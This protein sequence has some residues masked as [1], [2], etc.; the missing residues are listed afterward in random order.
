MTEL[1]PTRS[2]RSIEDVRVGL[3]LNGVETDVIGFSCRLLLVRVVRC[4]AEAKQ[5]MLKCPK[6]RIKRQGSRRR[7]IAPAMPL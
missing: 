3:N 2:L 1:H 6:P 4:L 7:L 5:T